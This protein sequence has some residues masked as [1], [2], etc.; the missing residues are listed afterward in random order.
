MQ[1]LKQQNVYADV[2]VRS[3]PLLLMPLDSDV[4]SLEH[5]HAFTD[6]HL[7]ADEDDPDTHTH[8]HTHTPS[9]IHDART[10]PLPLCVVCVLLARR[11]VDA[12]RCGL[13]HLAAAAA[14]RRG[15]PEHTGYRVGRKGKYLTH[16]DTRQ[17]NRQSRSLSCFSA[18]C[19]SMCV[20]M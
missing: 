19:A 16:T 17:T 5:R 6:F 7:V 4:L 3:Y 20:S 9:T 18:V 15:H 2:Q 14:L 12:L 1:A 11:S 13:V 10:F 8:T